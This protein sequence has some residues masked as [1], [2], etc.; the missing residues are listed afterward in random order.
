MIHAGHVKWKTHH[1]TSIWWWQP[2]AARNLWKHKISGSFGY[3]G[4]GARTNLKAY[5]HWSQM[6]DLSHRHVSSWTA[7]PVKRLAKLNQTNGSL[8]IHIL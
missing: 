7:P 2:V 1:I 4:K 3:W 6:I 5:R 8:C